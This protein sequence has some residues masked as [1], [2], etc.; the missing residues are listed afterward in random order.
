MSQIKSGDENPAR[1]QDR[2]GFLHFRLFRFFGFPVFRGSA[3]LRMAAKVTALPAAAEVPA[4]DSRTTD[5]T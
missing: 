1:S 2:A 3:F 4:P 5:G